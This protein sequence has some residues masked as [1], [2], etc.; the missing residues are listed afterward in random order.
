VFNLKNIEKNHLRN[1]SLITL[2]FVG[3]AV[4]SLYVRH[5][6]VEEKDDKGNTLNKKASSI[7]CASAQEQ[8]VDRILPY[9]NEDELNVYQRARN[10]HKSSR[11]KNATIKSYNKATG[12]EA[13]LGYLY[14][15][16]EI[17]RMNELLKLG[18]E[19]NEN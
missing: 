15:S 14:L 12:L 4:Y 1:Y 5:K 6:L 10:T 7:V 18:E 8:F 17:D 16:G 2:A 3:D 11:A 19:S 9:L 13:V